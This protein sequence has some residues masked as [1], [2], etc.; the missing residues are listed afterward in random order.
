[1]RLSKS[2]FILIAAIIIFCFIL[3]SKA[4]SGT[5]YQRTGGVRK[6]SSGGY[7]FYNS[8][9]Q[10]KGSSAS[11]GRGYTFYDSK[12]N[13]V[14]TLKKSTKSRRAYTYYDAEGIRRGYL[15]KS[16]TG[17]YYYQDVQSGKIVDALPQSSSGIGGLSPDVFQGQ[18][19]K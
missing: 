14:G 4:F 16:V 19:S 5:I 1:M 10:R 13:K 12:G 18:Q 3:S 15:K 7:D 8:S 2:S 17:G 9:G 6:N 11:T